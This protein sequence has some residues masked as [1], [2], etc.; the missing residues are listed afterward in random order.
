MVNSFGLQ[1]SISIENGRL[2]ILCENR[3][4]V[5]DNISTNLYFMLPYSVIALLISDTIRFD[6]IE[7]HSTSQVYYFC[8]FVLIIIVSITEVTNWWLSNNVKVMMRAPQNSRWI[9]LLH[10]EDNPKF[11]E[12]YSKV[13][14]KWID[15]TCPYGLTVI[16][17]FK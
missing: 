14:T 9:A 8:G 10:T 13:D 7:M 11:S 1:V 16:Q 6:S 12:L 17:N 3:H 15:R 4:T 2:E 5:A